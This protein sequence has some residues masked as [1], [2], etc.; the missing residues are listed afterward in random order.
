M[1]LGWAAEEWAVVDK[2]AGS[3]RV[4]LDLLRAQQGSASGLARH[5]DARLAALVTY[6]RARSRYYGRMYRGLPADRVMLRG[7]PP[8]TKPELMAS[9]DE[10]VTD[11]AVTRAGVKAFIADPAR[12]GTLYQGRYFVCTTSGTTGFPGLFVHDPG[13]CIVYQSFSYRL[14]L[15]WLSAR[16]WLDMA[17]LRGRWAAVVGTG[18]H[19]AGAGWMEFQRRRNVW[20]RHHY[21]VISLQQP[22]AALV[23][24]LNAFDPAVLTSYPSAL[25]LLVEEQAAGRLRVRPVIVE[26]G[27]ES[28]DEDGRARIAAGLGGALHDVYSASECMVM[29]FDCEQ[30]WL[31][32]NSD[33]V[34]L[35]PVD[36]DYGPTAPGKPS[37]TVLLTNLA[38][39]IQPIIRYDLGDTV[40]ARPDPCPC[41]NPL[42]AIRVQGRRDD[43]LRL[44]A[45]NGCTVSILPLAVGSVLDETPGVHRS[46]LVQTGP[47]SVL[48][49]LAPNPGWQAGQVW[50]SACRNLAGY[51]AA[52][53]LAGVEI[54]RAAEAPETS[55]TSGKFRQVIAGHEQPADG[56]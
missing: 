56:R 14:D 22:L 19:F 1:A 5:Q 16:Q 11:P 54:I 6:A 47:A 46:Q 52:Q 17:R 44:R 10:W 48:L 34:I 41:G 55:A 26:L 3:V 7:L 18:A 30:G 25:E 24:A 32:V 45:T 4:A 50:D 9:F 38:N 28:V 42:P 21:R 31:H 29:A 15:A 23:G 49:R 37:H 39:R 51:L 13:A 12:T 8:V 35:E 20:R 27:G 40:V 33:W 53:G 36:A 43:V 2:P